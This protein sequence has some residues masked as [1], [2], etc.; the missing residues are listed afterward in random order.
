MPR[1]L[2]SRRV[3]RAAPRRSCVNELAPCSMSGPRP[4]PPGD[5]QPAGGAERRRAAPRRYGKGPGTLCRAAAPGLAGRLPMRLPPRGTDDGRSRRAS[6]PVGSACIPD[7][8][9][10][11][12]PASRPTSPPS[13]WPATPAPILMHRAR[14]RGGV[15]VRPFALPVTLGGILGSPFACRRAG[16]TGAADQQAGPAG[17]TPI[18]R[19]VGVQQ[20]RNHLLRAATS[21]HSPW[22]SS[23]GIGRPA[24]LACVQPPAWPTHQ[25]WSGFRSA[26]PTR[27]P[28][29]ALALS[30]QKVPSSVRARFG[31]WSNTNR[32]EARS[33]THKHAKTFFRE[34]SLRQRHIEKEFA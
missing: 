19:H 17:R 6:R 3:T 14:S 31:N 1:S 34:L 22:L 11:S 8:A 23:C 32:I 16:E 20:R 29:P 13:P 25:A 15:V 26:A 33:K 18:V 9:A 12:R 5:E 30:T 7:P 4:A 27:T 21:A 10:A 24:A 28:C 2:Y